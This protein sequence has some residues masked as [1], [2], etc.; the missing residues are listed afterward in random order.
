MEGKKELTPVDREKYLENALK[1]ADLAVRDSYSTLLLDEQLIR[2][3]GRKRKPPEPV[4]L[5]MKEK[6]F[7]IAKHTKN[8]D[9]ARMALKMERDWERA[10]RGGRPPLGGAVDD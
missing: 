8:S 6:F 3:Q 5:E 4:P 2:E 7:D 10:S 1:N 9:K